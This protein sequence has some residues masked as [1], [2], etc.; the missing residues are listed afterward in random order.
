VCSTSVR[1]FRFDGS[2]VCSLCGTWQAP[3]FGSRL[4][5]GGN[6]ASA[7]T[8][9]SVG[10][11][12][13]RSS[14]GRELDRG[15]LLDAAWER[16]PDALDALKTTAPQ[17]KPRLGSQ[18]S[19]RRYTEELRTLGIRS[20]PTMIAFPEQYGIMERFFGS[21]KDE[22]VWTKDYDTR[23]ETIQAIDA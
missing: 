8:L 12:A 3:T 7:R 18:F 19:S 2:G 20:R 22:E 10:L 13:K 14:R 15:A 16:F 4:Q 21:L 5:H 11:R 17:L 6:R 1:N 23:A 9:D